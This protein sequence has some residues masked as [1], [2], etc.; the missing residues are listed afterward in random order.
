MRI[1]DAGSFGAH[2]KGLREAAGFTQEELATIAGLSVHAVSSLE[3]GQRRRPQLDTVRALAGALE[4]DTDARGALFE[5]ARTTASDTV[6]EELTGG[7]PLAPTNLIGRDEA[8]LTLQHWL[9]QP[10]M[11]LITLTGPGGAGKS[12]LALELAH[13]VV[14]DGGTRVVYVPLAAIQEPSFVA[15]GI[16]EAIGLSDLTAQELPAR[17]RMAC[18]DRAT[19]LLLDNFEHVLKAA[20]LVAELLKSI[21]SLKLLVTSRAPLRVRGER[22]FAVGPLDLDTDE[23]SGARQPADLDS[24]PAVQLFMERVRDV[25]PDFRLSPENGATVRAICQK[26]DALPLA[27]ELAAPWMKTLTAD[28]LLRRLERNVLLSPVGGRDLPERQQTMSAT[29]DWSYRLLG[30]NEQRTFRR[31]GVLRGRFRIEAAVAVLADPHGS[32]LASGD[33]LAPVADLIDKSLLLRAETSFA[34]RPRYQMLETVRAYA[35]TE[36]VASGESDAAL[37]GLAAYCAR[38]ANGARAGLAGPSQVEWLDRIRDDLE[39]YRTTLD[40]LIERERSADAADVAWNLLFFWLIRARGIEALQWCQ[41][42]LN[43]PRVPPRTEAKALVGGSV[44]LFT[45]GQVVQAREWLTRALALGPDIDADVRAMAEILFGHVEQSGGHL[46]AARQRF[47]ASLDQFRTLSSAWGI[48]NA[49]MGMASVAL[50][51]RDIVTAERLLD[52]AT[53][54]LQQ[55]G[56]WFLNLPLYIRANLAVQ[57]GQA[58]AAIEYARKSLIC[59]CELHDKFAFVYALAPLAAAAVLKGEDSWAAR[60]L[61]TRDAVTEQTGASSVD[62]S[63]RELLERTEREVRGRLGSDRWAEEYAA[64]RRASIDS[65]LRDIEEART[66]QINGA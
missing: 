29:I 25:Q 24:S 63:V 13:T 56:P 17:A 58:D 59:S 41:R 66:S 27:L 22:E 34:K 11:R 36:L 52:E 47:A 55:A 62:T 33:M 12:R 8:L 49:F 64:G 43:L 61:G 31:L 2:L 26:L 32:P 44:M 23:R 3:R 37:E 20:P 39:N 60:V 9:T 38:E 4:L 7:L 30:P 10:S 5:S 21:P 53:S 18:G 57:R 6:V 19:L 46:E 14:A 16:A 1:R 65:L 35:A 54:A 42:V 45:Q 15:L 50:A 48:G 28:D 51:S 40:W